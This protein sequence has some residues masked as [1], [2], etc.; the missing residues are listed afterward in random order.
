MPSPFDLLR[1]RPRQAR[2][3]LAGVFFGFLFCLGAVALLWSNEG[4]V[5]LSKVAATSMV[6]DATRI[7]PTAEG[8]AGLL[9]EWQHIHDNHF[10][11]ELAN[12]GRLQNVIREQ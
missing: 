11:A 9:T 8:K 4:R 10:L 7:E 1:E 2:G 5:D 6:V 3:V 12:S